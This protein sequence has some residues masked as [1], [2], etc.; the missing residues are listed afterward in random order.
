MRRNYIFFIAVFVLM[1]LYGVTFAQTLPI[2]NGLAYL[3]STQ[4][5]EGYWG[6]AAEVP[7]NAVVDTCT[8]VETLNYLNETGAEYNTAIQWINTTEVSNNDYLFTKML[9]LSQAGIDVSTIKDYL[10][11]IKND[12]IGWGVTEGFTSDVKR[13]ALALQALRVVNYPDQNL[14]Y[15]AI[16]YLKSNQNA[17]GGWGLKN[18]MDSEVYYTALAIITFSK[19]KATYD[20]QT[21]INKAVSYLFAHQNP[22]GSFGEGTVYETALSFIALIESGAVGAENYTLLQNTIAYLTSTQLP[23]GSWNDDPYSTALALR[24]LYIASSEQTQPTDTAGSGSLEKITRSYSC[25]TPKIHKNPDRKYVF[26]RI[27]FLAGNCYG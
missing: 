23:N 18:G 26:L 7:Y 12:D 5:P 2:T 24:A 27:V 22:V 4:S 1:L 6:D 8:V 21:E 20:L 3:Q 14:I 11:G 13:T 9:V 25:P 16:N 15:S 10:L 19:F 17:D